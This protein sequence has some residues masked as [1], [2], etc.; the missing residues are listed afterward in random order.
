MN[1]SPPDL[2]PDLGRLRTVEQFL[3]LALER[4]R[5]QIAKQERREQEQQRAIEAR[6]LAPDW[7]IE[8]LP[9][10]PTYVHAGDC[11][12]AGKRSTGVSREQARRALRD[13]A[14]ACSACTPDSALGLLEG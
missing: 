6:P 7:L 1:D 4:V 12:A 9:S 11:W 2:P 13:G 8:Q 5:E 14:T 3:V 10:G